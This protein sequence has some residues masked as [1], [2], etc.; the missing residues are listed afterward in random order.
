MKP[1]DT[2]SQAY[3]ILIDVYRRM[4]AA[5]KV[6]RIFDAYQTG[7][8]LAMA[9]LRGLHPDATEENIWRFWA[10]QNLGK[11]LFDQVYGDLPDG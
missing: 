1:R 9:G 5:E 11:K 3:E 4:P 7:K 8:Q 10:R 2:S 6:T